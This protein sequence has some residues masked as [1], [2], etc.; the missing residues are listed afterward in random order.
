MEVLIRESEVATLVS[1]ADAFN[2]TTEAHLALFRGTATNVTRSRARTPKM[3][4]HTMSAASVALDMACA[5]V[6]SGSATGF[7]SHILL[8]RVSSGEL[9]AII[10]ANTI[11][12][13][14]TAAAS[15]VAAKALV[16]RPVRTLGVIG[17]G[18][19]GAGMVRSF[20]DKATGFPLVKVLLF[21]RDKVK[22]G[23]CVKE[24]GRDYPAQAAESLAQ[25]Q[26]ESDIIVTT[27]NSSKPVVVSEGLKN[28]AHIS[29]VGSN[30][31]ARVEL[32]PRVITGASLVVT[33][34][35]EGAKA[36]AGKLLS[37]IENGKLLWSQVIELSAVL[38]AL[39]GAAQLGNFGE[40]GYSVYCSQGLAVQDL[41]LA[42][43]V[44]KRRISS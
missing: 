3:S 34:S 22:L 36:E 21:R 39:Q 41:F 7:S 27:T 6:Y 16:R 1:A 9:L 31:L 12:Q 14:R 5:K 38:G 26:A 8:Y 15:A 19:Q 29:A 40:S 13:L 43:L 42:A 2:T 32:E 28:V 30:S 35:V 23:Q 10:E 33:D 37:P 11:G 4:L 18:Y 25:L 17:A 44:Y 24:L 20:C